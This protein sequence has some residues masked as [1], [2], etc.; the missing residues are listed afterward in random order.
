M[1]ADGKPWVA[2][3]GLACQNM[4]IAEC[5][6]VTCA[7]STA[8]LV[9]GDLQ[10]YDPTSNA[11]YR[12]ILAAAAGSAT[13]VFAAFSSGDFGAEKANLAFVNTAPGQPAVGKALFYS[14]ICRHEKLTLPRQARNE[15]KNKTERQRVV[16]A[17]RGEENVREF[18][19][20]KLPFSLSDLS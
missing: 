14:P 15:F 5:G 17:V 7:T 18:E 12:P 13:S 11:V 1:G 6:D 2:Y 9:A 16:S 4:S 20:R 19:V 8:T 10:T 3:M